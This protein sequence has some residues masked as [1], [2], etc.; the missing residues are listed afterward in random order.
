MN[1]EYGLAGNSLLNP[2]QVV[3]VPYAS[4][5]KAQAGDLVCVKSSPA[6]AGIESLP[7]KFCIAG[8]MGPRRRKRSGAKVQASL[9]MLVGES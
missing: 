7:V 8:T 1:A 5:K 9:R 4:S 3:N 2:V 6:G